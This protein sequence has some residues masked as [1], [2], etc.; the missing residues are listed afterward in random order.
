M[1]GGAWDGAV[2]ASVDGWCIAWIPAL[3]GSRTQARSAIHASDAA[4]EANERS[5][6]S[7]QRACAPVEHIVR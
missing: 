6:V 7:C 5:G 1:M 2:E 3:C 4:S